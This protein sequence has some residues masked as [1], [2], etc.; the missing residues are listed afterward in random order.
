MVGGGPVRAESEAALLRLMLDSH[1][2]LAMPPETHFIPRLVEAFP[3]R[4]TTADSFSRALAGERRWA[5]FG[6]DGSE[7]ADR[8]GQ[9]GS[10]PARSSWTRRSDGSTAHPA[11][12]HALRN[13]S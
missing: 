4:I 8:I 1:P 3:D 7:L 9:L 5:D 11:G 6:L 2:E 13:H 10:A 12:S